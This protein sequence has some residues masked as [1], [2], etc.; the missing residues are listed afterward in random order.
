MK[1]IKL[2][3]WALLAL[4]SITSCSNHTEEI[5]TQEYEIKLTSEITPSR[6][7]SWDYQSTQIVEGQQVGVTITDAKSGHNNVAWTV[8]DTGLLTN[9]G[10]AIYYG[11]GTA[12]ITAYHPYNSSWTTGKSHEFS[13]ST[14]QSDEENYRNSD[15]LW[16]TTAS[17]KA[18]KA[19]PLIFTHK[20]AKINVK[21]VP[22]KE[23]TDLNNATI[24]ICN[25]KISATFNPM[26]GELSD[27]IG[28]P[29]EIEASVTA[30]NIYTASAIVIPQEIPIG[31]FIKIT[32]GNKTY[33]YTLSEA[34]KIESGDS[35]NYT[36][37]M[38][39]DEEEIETI[40]NN[41]IW[42]TSS[43]GNI[44]TP[45]ATND[46]GANLVSNVYK[47][48]KGII[49]FDSDVTT[50]GYQAF[51]NCTSLTGITIPNSVVNIKDA[52][53]FKCNSLIN[54]LIP[55]SVTSIENQAFEGCIN[56]QS[57]TIPKSVTTIGENV[58]TGAYSL[59]RIIV[60]EGNLFYDS[61]ENCNAIIKTKS[62]SLIRGCNNTTIPKSV[63]SIEFNAFEGCSFLTNVKIPDNVTSIG[64]G[65]FSYCI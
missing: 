36:L 47:D 8:G 34:I 29:Q 51:L 14:N 33:Y 9:T 23:G 35:Y 58:F 40:P 53:F 22:E 1:R 11:N 52:A 16:A 50:I 20:L 37:T 39:G 24:S 48:G 43:D 64:G 4:T 38:T 45:F 57:I 6:V 25:T 55:N 15:L 65:A 62:N 12:T 44:V 28:E 2:L 21:L 17:S 27:A 60:E 63:T 61:R 49:S 5:L 26:T 10:N 18:D 31:K 54:I 19:I 46:F 3:G 32:H 30:D 41:Q 56:L 59:T 13:V 42:Y 7:T